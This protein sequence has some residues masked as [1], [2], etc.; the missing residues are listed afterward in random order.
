MACR[1]RAALVGTDVVLEAVRA[2]AA[3]DDVRLAVAVLQDRVGRTAVVA[4]GHAGE[5]GQHA[6]P[7]RGEQL[8]GW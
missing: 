7:D 1:S 3:G 2:A 5:Q 6:E 4:Q 8:H